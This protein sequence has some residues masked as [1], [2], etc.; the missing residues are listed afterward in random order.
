M[1][2][3]KLEKV[4]IHPTN[5]CNLK[6]I[7]CDVSCTH[8]NA[9]DLDEEK[10]VDISNE[11]C[12]L[13]PSV[14]TISGG[15]EPLLRH[16]L[17]MDMIK[18]LY[19]GNIKAEI[20][21]NGTLVSNQ[22]ARTI[23]ECCHDYLLSIHS[24]SE[25]LDEFLR[26]KK[27]SINNSFDGVKQIVYWKEKMK[28][29]EPQIGTV[30]VINK[31][32]IKEIDK[33]IKKA[34]SLRINNVRLRMVHKWGD[35]YLPSQRQMKFLKK[36]LKNYENLASEYNLE[37]FYHFLVED[38]FPETKEKPVENKISKD[39]FS[40]KLP[41]KEMVIFAD[42]R[43]APCCNFITDT[44][45]SVGVDSIKN[46]TLSEVWFGKKFNLLRKYVTEGDKSK[47][48][49]T[50]KECSIDLKPIDKGYK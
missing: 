32:N 6:C 20:I 18:I 10:F 37:L 30:M 12:K 46:K 1:M 25:N 26:G 50:C 28:K 23:A 13:Q 39:Q 14:V 2:D 4:Q 5:R 34:F 36:N 22:M 16:N 44:E 33:M 9:V 11:L 21:T 38:L 31:F 27:D 40:C 48:P 24:T 41:F 3:L 8:A 49:K 17:L 29:D 15:G 45:D 42:G 19:S 47:L 43:V 35:K 7:F